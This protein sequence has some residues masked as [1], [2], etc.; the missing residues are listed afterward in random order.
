MMRLITIASTSGRIGARSVATAA[1]FHA[2]CA[3]AGSGVAD[4]Y[5]LTGWLI[6]NGAGD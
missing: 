6:T 1:I 2:S 3:D 5:T 4:G